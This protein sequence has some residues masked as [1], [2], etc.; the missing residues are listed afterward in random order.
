MIGTTPIDDF[1][2]VLFRA[3]TAP[4]RTKGDYARQ[5]AD[6]I[7]IAASQGYIST[8]VGDGVYGPVW[9]ITSKGLERLHGKR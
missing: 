4:F 2:R 3:W 5:A 6:V 7:A 9:L 1:E 8:N